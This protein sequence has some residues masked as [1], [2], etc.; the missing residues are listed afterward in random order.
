MFVGIGFIRDYVVVCGGIKD[1]ERTGTGEPTSTVY[2]FSLK[3]FQWERWPDMGIVRSHPHVT[4][5][6]FSKPP[7][8]FFLSFFG[9]SQKK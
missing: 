3:N 6:L 4:T 9:F 8:V 2:A 5:S 7:K 1:A